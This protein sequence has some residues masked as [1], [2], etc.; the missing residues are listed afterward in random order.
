MAAPVRDFSGQIVA[1]VNVSGPSFRLRPHADM[2]GEAL[3]RSAAR[4]SAA[5]AGPHDRRLDADAVA[6]GE[7]AAP[8]PGAGI[9]GADVVD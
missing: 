8:A 2:A 9:V 7:V 3:R 5:I 1:A 4:L 6:D